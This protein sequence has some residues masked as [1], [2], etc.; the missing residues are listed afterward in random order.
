LPAPEIEPVTSATQL[1][2]IV[3][4]LLWVQNAL[5]IWTLQ[6]LPPTHKIVVKI[7]VLGTVP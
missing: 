7:P 5:A 1:T 6:Y 2:N 3:T 4:G